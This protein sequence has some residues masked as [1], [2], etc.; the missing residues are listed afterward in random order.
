MK[1]LTIPE[2]VSKEHGAPS[3]EEFHCITCSDEALL[4]R[5]LSV[6]ALQGLAL[7]EIEGGGV[8]TEVDISLVED[9]SP[10]NMLLVHGG[11]ALT[12]LEGAT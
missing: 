5:V 8:R 6:H 1:D 2:E 12:R 7:V 3:G 4:A 11:V 9:V 10:G